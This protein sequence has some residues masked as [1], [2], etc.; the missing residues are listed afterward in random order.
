MILPTDF[1]GHKP[2]TMAM[3]HITPPKEPDVEESSTD[4]VRWFGGSPPAIRKAPVM[5]WFIIYDLINNG[6]NHLSTGAGFRKHP[7]YVMY[8][9]DPV[10]GTPNSGQSL[11]PGFWQDIH[12]SSEH[13]ISTSKSPFAAYPRLIM[14]PAK[15]ALLSRTFEVCML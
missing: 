14:K 3:A 1:D 15:A 13:V 8:W 4:E 5:V 11:T 9:N 6:I 7:Q 12:Y 10:L 2:Y